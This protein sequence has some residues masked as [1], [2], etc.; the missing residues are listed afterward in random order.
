MS[1]QYPSL[2]ELLKAH[3]HIKGEPITHTR[4][5]NKSLNVYGGSYSIPKDEVTRDQFYKLYA[6]H[7]FEEGKQEYLTEVQGECP[8]VLV[9]LDFRYSPEV[10]DRQHTKKHIEGLVGLYTR[11]IR[12]LFTVKGTTTVF[13]MEKPDVNMLEDKTKDGIHMIIGYSM[14]HSQQQ[15]LRKN[16]LEHIGGVLGD[17]PLTNSYAD[18]LDEGISKG[19]TNWQ[20]F[21]SRKPGHDAYKL[22]H[23][24][25]VYGEGNVVEQSR[26][27]LPKKRMEY[28]RTCSAQYEGF[29]KVDVRPEYVND[30]AQ[31]DKKKKTPATSK[32]TPSDIV[33]STDKQIEKFWDYAR[34]LPVG[35]VSDRAGWF[36]LTCL[37]KNILGEGDYVNY[38]T[39]CSCIDGYDESK[40]RATYDGLKRMD[41]PSWGSLFYWV[42]QK[43][44][45]RK[46]LYDVRS[47]WDEETTFNRFKMDSMLPKKCMY[48]GKGIDPALVKADVG[49]RLD[50]AKRYFEKYH[51]KLMDATRVICKMEHGD[52]MYK[53][54]DMVHNYANLRCIINVE[55]DEEDGKLDWK[56]GT[57]VEWWKM[58]TDMLTYD[59][60]DF[61]PPPRKCPSSIYN[62]FK[63]L[64]MWDVVSDGM[65]HDYSRVTD[66]LYCLCGKDGTVYDYMVKYL[67]H[68]VQRPSERPNVCI[69]MNS[70]QGVGKNVFW[71]HFTKSI[72]GEQ[73][74]LSTATIDHVMGRFN[75]NYNRLV[76]V[77]DEVSGRD[78]FARN[79]QIKSLIT[80]DELLFEKKGIDGIKIRNCGRYVILSNND[81]PVKIEGSDRR[82]VVMR[83]ADDHIG[84]QEYF[85]EVIKVF[86]DD[87]AM[88]AFYEYL[89]S[90]DIDGYSL[91][92]N[93][94]ITALYRELQEVSH[95]HSV[96]FMIDVYY[97]TLPEERPGFEMK[98]SS[99]YT[100]YKEWCE[101]CSIKEPMTNNAFGRK[102][103]KFTGV[104]NKRTK[105]GVVYYID[106]TELKQ[107]FIENNMW[108][109][110]EEEM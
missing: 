47:K 40:N 90:V 102:V 19:H 17:L 9:D 3:T 61:L 105:S 32:G 74:L 66:L 35:E 104:I 60:M 6:R 65:P 99:L 71:E 21:G 92:A 24:Y 70:K 109:T 94:P 64:R 68:L 100:R 91:P 54:S 73:Y 62:T 69:V 23:V 85:K 33:L 43:T 38:D 78:T 7:V 34:L 42:N 36:L 16:V 1:Q 89:M 95:H 14:T 22:T 83:C 44:E 108:E 81:T 58:Q 48:E 53:W 87:Q 52:V 96:R 84:D 86:E 79:D 98:G 45:D 82:F 88:R 4:I 18:V 77:M 106:L 27:E 49:R 11:T 39:Y 103:K 15:L 2:Y 93:R 55:V 101:K 20:L 25:D 51:G 80:A 46:A 110:I 41:T 12:T 13:V 37:H 72:M 76:V 59:T 8:P 10:E 28:M 50:K 57:F 29:E 63:G 5:G 67:A 56:T 26:K 97:D 75:M 30:L 31:F 107:S